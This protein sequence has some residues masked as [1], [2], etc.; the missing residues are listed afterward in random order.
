MKNEK[1]KENSMVDA[2][3]RG[4]I[5]GRIFLAFNGARFRVDAIGPAFLVLHWDEVAIFVVALGQICADHRFAAELLFDLFEAFAAVRF[6]FDGAATRVRDF[7][8]GGRIHAPTVAGRG[9]VLFGAEVAFNGAAGGVETGRAFATA[10]FQDFSVARA[11]VVQIVVH[12]ATGP[13]GGDG[14]VDRFLLT[15]SRA[16]ALE[17][18]AGVTVDA[19]GLAGGTPVLTGTV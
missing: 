9:V 3:Q 17:L 8:A 2:W 18:L 19:P 12:T 10:S 5:A 13:H 16:R 6:R 15:G 1:Q 14:A 4:F 7:L 11:L